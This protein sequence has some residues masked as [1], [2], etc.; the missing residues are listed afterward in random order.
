MALAFALLLVIHGL[1][2]LLGFVKAFGLADM[3]QLSRPLSMA[4]GIAWLLAATMFVAAAAALFAWPRGWW[5]VAGGAAILSTALIVPEW[6][7]A[8]AGAFVNAVVVIG[9]LFGF[10]SQGPFSLR[11]QY[12]RD[13]AAAVAQRGSAEIVRDVD[14]A[15][16]PPLVQR[17]LRAAGV[18]GQ[19][20]VRTYR[21]RAHGRIRSGPDA[22]WIPLSFEQINVVDP[23]TRLFYMTGSMFGIPVQGY[24][25]YVGSAATMRVKAAALVP[26]ADAAGREMTQSETVTIFNDMCFLAPATLIDPRI[27]WEGSQ[28]RSVGAAFSNAGCTIRAQLVFDDAGDLIDFR[29]D[30]RYQLAGGGKTARKQRWSTPLEAYRHF[31]RMR[32]ASRGAALWHEPGGAYAYIELAIDD[33]DY[34]VAQR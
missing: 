25:R 19:P 10:L 2:H 23:P 30:D 1:I 12:E 20:R 18:V 16:L 8:K 5:F 9:V 22:R 31:G 26:V 24:H 7:D 33:V 28:E 11:A 15:P 13:A 3:P 34:N 27:V 14:L 6:S 32:L 29:S 17:Y 4:A 21:A